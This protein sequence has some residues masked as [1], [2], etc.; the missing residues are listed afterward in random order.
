MFST[1]ITDS[2]N[3]RV[4]ECAG[5]LD[6]STATQLGDVLA[7]AIDPEHPFIVLDLDKVEYM[8]SAGLR[9]IVAGFKQVR[10]FKGDV[11]LATASDRTVS[12]LDIVGLSPSVYPTVQAAIKSFKAED[13]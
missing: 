6:G 4:V 2:G 8:S 11:R 12:V 5:R 10:K 13:N 7:Q 1:K 9:E 3:V